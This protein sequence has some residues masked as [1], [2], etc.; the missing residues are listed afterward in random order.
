M[1]G[2]IQAAEGC[3]KEGPMKTVKGQKELVVAEKKM[4]M[5]KRIGKIPGNVFA[6]PPAFEW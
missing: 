5:E 3:E 1:R 6:R 2:E 4:L